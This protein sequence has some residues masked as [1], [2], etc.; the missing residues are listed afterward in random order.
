M[1][2]LTGCGKTS[3]ASAPPPECPPEVMDAAEI[4]SVLTSPA[5]ETQSK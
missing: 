4:Q 5:D 2:A 3:E 1:F